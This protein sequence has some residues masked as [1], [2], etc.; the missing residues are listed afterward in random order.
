MIPKDSGMIPTELPGR[1]MIPGWI[2]VSLGIASGF[3]AF[4]MITGRSPERI[5]IPMKSL[6]IIAGFLLA[7]AGVPRR[8]KAAPERPSDSQDIGRTH[9]ESGAE[10]ESCPSPEYF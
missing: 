7:S 4:W 8:H 10:K 9:N 6:G 5:W 1:G 2:R 3:L